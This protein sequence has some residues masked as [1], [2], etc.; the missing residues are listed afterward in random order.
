M[1]MLNLTFQQQVY[2]KFIEFVLKIWVLRMSKMCWVET[3]TSIFYSTGVMILSFQEEEKTC[4]CVFVLNKYLYVYNLPVVQV[5]V[6]T[7]CI[8][9]SS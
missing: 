4:V 8:R 7:A 2:F 5:Q 3:Y 1:M 6:P 9:A